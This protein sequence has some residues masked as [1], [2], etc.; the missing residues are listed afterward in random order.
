M[1]VTFRPIEKWLGRSGLRS[2]A[3]RERSRFDS[4]WSQTLD[5]LTYELGRLGARAV[6]VRLALTDQDIRR[7]GW[8]RANARPE[9]PGVVVEWQIR[10]AWFGRANDKYDDWQ[11]NIRGIALTLK[12]LRDVERWGVVSGEQYE[13]MRLELETPGSGENAA[14]ALLDSYG[15]LRAA[16]RATHPDQ[17]GD[18]EEFIRVQEEK[19]VLGL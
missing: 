6:V 3:A 18:P 12:S 1:D 19:R 4:G 8:P 7:D 9:H 16:L 14:R 11:S 13:G 15:G 10:D 17:G 2:P 5:L